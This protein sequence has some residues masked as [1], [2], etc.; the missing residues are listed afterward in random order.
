MC[1]GIAIWRRRLPTRQARRDVVNSTGEAAVSEMKS[2]VRYVGPWK[3]RWYR[4]T[5]ALQS[6]WMFATVWL[7]MPWHYRITL[8]WE[9][10]GSDERRLFPE[11]AG[12]YLRRAV[13]SMRIGRDTE[14]QEQMQRQH[15]LGE[16]RGTDQT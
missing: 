3:R 13:F 8:L 12:R 16:S 5:L 7:R 1:G 2:R 4:A 10:I 15:D 9:E 6:A 11:F 14:I